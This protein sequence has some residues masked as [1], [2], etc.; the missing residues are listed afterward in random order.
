MAPIIRKRV[1]LP[2]LKP[3]RKTNKFPT[4][5]P[6]HRPEKEAEGP[7]NSDIQQEAKMVNTPDKSDPRADIMGKFIRNAEIRPI[8]L[9][10]IPT[11][12]KPESYNNDLELAPFTP[13]RYTWAGEQRKGT[14]CHVTDSV[15]RV[16]H[17]RKAM[18]L[19]FLLAKPAPPRGKSKNR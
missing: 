17:T 10:S 19:E 9:G 3:A 8:A 15:D 12:S 1:I 2:I 14:S 18:G 16:G 7:N 11:C 5:N 13:I 4:E 6:Y